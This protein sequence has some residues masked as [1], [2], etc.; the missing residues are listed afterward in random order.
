M[1]KVIPTLTIINSVVLIAFLIYHFT[2]E[3]KVAYVDSP[4]FVV[5]AC[6]QGA[7]APT[8]NEMKLDSQHKKGIW[9]SLFG[10]FG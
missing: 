5:V 9:K 3:R 2:A 7:L 8:A 10:K 1:R 4:A 6:V